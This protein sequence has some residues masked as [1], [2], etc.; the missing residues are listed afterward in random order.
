MQVRGKGAGCQPK[1]A[2]NWGMCTKLTPGKPIPLSSHVIVWKETLTN[3]ILLLA[4]LAS[5]PS[6]KCKIM[7]LMFDY[8][9][10]YKNLFHSLLVQLIKA[11]RNAGSYKALIIRNL[12]S[13]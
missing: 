2:S 9:M 10:K 8:V 6:G 13:N 5:L 12:R 7:I 11:H 1:N 4:Y 3:T